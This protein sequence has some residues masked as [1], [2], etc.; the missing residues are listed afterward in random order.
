MS[1]ATSSPTP[2]LNLFII[3]LI[4]INSDAPTTPP[5]NV[6][7]PRSLSVAPPSLALSLASPAP[8][9]TAKDAPRY[10]FKAV[11]AKIPPKEPRA[12]LNF[13]GIAA[14]L[15]SSILA[16]TLAS[17]ARY[18]CTASPTFCIFSRTASSG[19]SPNTLASPRRPCSASVAPPASIPFGTS[20]S[21][22]PK[23]TGRLRCISS[24]SR[25]N[26]SSLAAL[27]SSL[28]LVASCSCWS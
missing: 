21:C 27:R 23:V 15:P 24:N 17:G 6:A 28:D 19:P 3:L 2:F 18:S 10:G 5:P 14:P 20:C 26:A 8:A 22:C 1:V 9:V 12:S 16:C 7:S 25:R 4:G 11:V 13:L